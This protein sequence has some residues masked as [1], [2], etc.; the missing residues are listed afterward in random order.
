MWY[1]E[2]EVWLRGIGVIFHAREIPRRYGDIHAGRNA[3][4][5]A[6]RQMCRHRRGEKHHRLL[7]TVRISAHRGAEASSAVY[8]NA[9]EASTEAMLEV[10]GLLAAIRNLNDILQNQSVMIWEPIRIYQ[11]RRF[12]RAVISPL[13]VVM[14]TLRAIA[15]KT[16]SALA[17]RARVTSRGLF[18][19]R[20]ALGG[21]IG[22]CQAGACGEAA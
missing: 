10:D 17:Q 21:S 15:P 12:A 8:I 22:K 2:R 9:H 4:K 1:F 5:S 7:E 6:T 13:L 3:G 20:S 11:R 18:G 14:V 19:A 16:Q